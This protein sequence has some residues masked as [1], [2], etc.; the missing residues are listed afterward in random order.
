VIEAW[1]AYW[2]HLRIVAPASMNQ[3]QERQFYQERD[4]LVGA[5]LTPTGTLSSWLG[6]CLFTSST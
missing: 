1:K 6:S 3:D 4:G 5:G 2:N